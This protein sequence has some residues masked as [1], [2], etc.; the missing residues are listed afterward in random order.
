[1]MQ[2]RVRVFGKSEYGADTAAGLPSVPTA[3]A[4]SQA[5][6]R[7]QGAALRE[8]VKRK[9]QS[10]GSKHDGTNTSN[11]NNETPPSSEGRA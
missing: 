5:V 11:P 2:S 1:M 3:A 4:K 10:D 9:R 6:A 7:R 8:Q